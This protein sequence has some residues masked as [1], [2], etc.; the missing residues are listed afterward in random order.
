M[1]MK[2]KTYKRSLAVMLGLA[3]AVQLPGAVPFHPMD[4]YAYTGAAT[5]KASSLN[6][7]SGA[8]TGYQAIGRLAA[9]ASIQVLGE[10]RGTDG[11]T[12]YQIRFSGTGG[13]EQTGY[14]SAEYVR[15]PVSYT[16]D[17]D[18]E[19]KLS[20]EGFP[21]SYKNGLRQLHAQ[22]PNW[23]FKAKKTGLDWNTVIENEALL[24]RNLV[25]SGSISSW[26]SVESGAYNWD[27]STWT[28]FDGSNW[29]AASEDIIRY[30]M[31][32]RNFLDDTYVFQFLSHEYN[33]ST[34]TRDGLAKM[35]EGSFLS[36]TTDSTGTGSS[37][38]STG[39]SG[40]SGSSG[41]S[42]GV[43]KDG[44]GRSQG[45]DQDVN[46]GPGVSG[47]SRNSGSPAGSTGEVSL[48]APHASVTPRNHNL[49]MTGI[50]VG[51]APGSSSQNT[52]APSGSSGSNAPSSSG[53]PN[54][55]GPGVSSGSGGS[56]SNV[57]V[58]QAPESGG[59]AS[60]TGSSQTSGPSGSSSSQNAGPSSGPSSSGSSSGTPSSNTGSG[61]KLY[62]DII[63]DA[64]AQ[65]GVSPY[66]LAAMI[67][68]EQGTNGGS[69]LISGNYSGYPG[70][71]NFFNVEAYQ[72]GSMSAIQTGLRYASQSG[73]Y[74]RPW[75]TVE[76]S[77]I[78]GAQNYG[79]NYVK[80][81]Q[82]TFYLKKFNVQGSNL[83]KHQ[84]MTNIQGAASEAERL[85][86][87][88]SSVKDSALEFQI[89][90]YN[91]MLETACAAP[92][93]DGSPNNKLSS[94]SAEGYSLTPSFGKDTESYNLIVNT[95]VS[96]IQVNAAAADSKASVSGAGSIP[97][98][99]STTDIAITVTAENGS[100]RTYTIHVVK[101]DGGPV[102]SGSS[103]S[104]GSPS[105][106]GSSEGPGGGNGSSG[107][108]SSGGSGSSG[109]G[110]TP[111][112]SNVTI[113]G[114]SP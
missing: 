24:G 101:Q 46:H 103:G 113:V 29:V 91:N 18:F 28:G 15:L 26:K 75:D 69:P 23:V 81:G 5:V 88:Y 85:S 41:S 11:K 92:V 99:G 60:G 100:A 64:A 108:G 53:S 19:A 48:E 98:N 31:D 17:S 55:G 43:S 79:D 50:G 8:G 110:N 94:L 45:K 61:S 49:V 71:Y 47:S 44:P 84:Y 38:G 14:V 97:L 105:S 66:V 95:S 52:G 39:A 59:Q 111:G 54:T 56:D 40:P 13:T 80:A 20:A 114:V 78:G 77:I 37:T 30:Y 42:G 21:E 68:Q 96:S 76:K 63:M 25:S 72:S 58:G 83:Y 67:L 86:K 89:P 51:E 12:W 102:S 90:V 16:T 22:Y 87:A 32:P 106:P 107:P 10:Q 34:Q 4:T 57:S 62:V 112:G 2:V 33:S 1:H 82:N 7:R 36:G 109:G 35:V 3:L 9:G 104:A 74:G 70:Y 65:S 93:G 6:V 27:N 73:S